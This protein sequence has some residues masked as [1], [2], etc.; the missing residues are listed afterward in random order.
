[1]QALAAQGHTIDVLSYH[2]GEDV[3]IESVTHQRTKRPPLVKRVPIGPSWQKALCD[4]AMMFKAVSGSRLKCLIRRN[5][6]FLYVLAMGGGSLGCG[7]SCRVPPTKTFT[8]SLIGWRHAVGYL[9]TA[10][11]C[12]ITRVPI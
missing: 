8:C 10:F 6:F 9:L 12:R 1:M 7:N 11:S 3:R 2:E 4:L 5:V